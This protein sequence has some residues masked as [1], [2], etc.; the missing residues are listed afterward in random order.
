M[1]P[2]LVKKQQQSTTFNPIPVDSSKVIPQTQIGVDFI[3]VSPETNTAE[4]RQLKNKVIKKIDLPFKNFNNSDLTTTNLSPSQ[5][6]CLVSLSVN[7]MQ[8]QMITE[9]TRS[10]KIPLDLTD[11]QNYLTNIAHCFCSIFK[12][13]APHGGMLLEAIRTKIERTEANISEQL[14]QKELEKK[15][16]FFGGWK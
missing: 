11:A 3:L 6:A 2:I 12:S 16:G 4:K 1:N 13:G 8:C 10:E 5:V 14:E 15:K 7:A 9:N